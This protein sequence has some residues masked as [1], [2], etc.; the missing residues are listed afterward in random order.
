VSEVAVIAGPTQLALLG[1][2][3][4]A[5]FDV[6]STGANTATNV[7]VDISIP[8]NVT[9]NSATASSGSCASGA[10]TVTCTLGSIAG[11]SSA[12][13]T[14]TTTAS[15][16]GND[17]FVATATA[18]AD[19]NAGNNQASLQVF[20][21]P[22]VDLDVSATMVS[23]VTVNQS[24][25]LTLSLQNLATIQASNVSLGL[26]FAGGVTID[27]ADWPLGTCTI[28]ALNVSCD[29]TAV[30][31]QANSAISIGVT[32][33]TEGTHSYSV[34]LAADETDINSAN[35]NASGNLSVTAVGGG[36]PPANNDDGGS[37]AMGSFLLAL[38]TAVG[39]VRRRRILR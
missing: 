11:G 9:F 20:V 38:I 33:V 22:A 30:A 3:A 13:V 2:V 36:P 18:D 26:N 4:S 34:T 10:G 15:N 1:T 8:G 37:G 16:V 28:N 25:T 19:T 6:S 21:D 35:N 31:A 23:A 32:G 27:S 5:R 24:T 39:I 17:T 14:V 7:A 12:N 29:A